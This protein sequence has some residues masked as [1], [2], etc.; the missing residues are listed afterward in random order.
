MANIFGLFGISDF[1]V[2]RRM[3]LFEYRIRQRGHLMKQ[4]EREK[5][6]YL[7]AYA[8]RVVKA[9]DKKG[10]KYVF[11]EFKDFYDEDKRRKAVLG[12]SYKTPVN[13]NLIAIAKRMK[14]YEKEGG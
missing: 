7:Q 4:L 1:D 11:E 2:A 5:E 8:N 10:K 12:S 6:I 14:E 9:T 3:T 13:E